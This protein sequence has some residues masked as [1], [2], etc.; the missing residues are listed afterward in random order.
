MKPHQIMIRNVSNSTLRCSFQCYSRSS[1]FIFKIHGSS[2]THKQDLI[3][4]LHFFFHLDASRTYGIGRCC[5]VEHIWP[6]TRAGI[7]TAT[8]K[9]TQ[10]T[11]IGKDLHMPFITRFWNSWNAG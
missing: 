11:L 2:Y 6:A 3:C 8:T 7:T 9:I 10:S 1:I 5:L 4:F